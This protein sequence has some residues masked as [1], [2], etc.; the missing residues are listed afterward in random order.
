M[1]LSSWA[2]VDGKRPL[3]VVVHPKLPGCKEE[4]T[5]HDAA[6][7]I[8][9][10]KALRWRVVG[11]DEGDDEDDDEDEDEDGEDIGSEDG[12]PSSSSD[13]EG[14]S[15]IGLGSMQP[16][17]EHIARVD[18]IDPRFFFLSQDLNRLAVRV[19]K[20]KSD[21]LFVNAS[22]SPNQQFHLELVMDLVAKAQ[23]HVR[24]DAD[25]GS[26]GGKDSTVA[27]FDRPRVVLAIFARR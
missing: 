25:E 18:R 19:A 23:R 16:K 11:I 21:V 14:L 24:N 17:G 12:E 22:L 10:A 20:T 7:A 8:G 27:V 6:E 1:G 2:R 3:A 26:F 9:L 4:H 15:K 13:D 5:A